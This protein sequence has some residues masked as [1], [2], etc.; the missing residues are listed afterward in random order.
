S[1]P[2]GARAFRLALTSRRLQPRANS[3]ARYL[4]PTRL[5]CDASEA[6]HG[7]NM[8]RY[9]ASQR[10]EAVAALQATHDP[11]AGMIAGDLHDLLGQPGV[12]GFHQAHLSHLVF[13]MCIKACRHQYELGTMR[14]QSRHPV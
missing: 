12:I 2:P 14:M 11:A 7:T 4:R 9:A 8:R 10:R 5:S 3:L 13:A 6:R 1:Q